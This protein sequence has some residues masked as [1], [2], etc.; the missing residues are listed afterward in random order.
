MVVKKLIQKTCYNQYVD[1]LYYQTENQRE[2]IKFNQ[3]TY[4]L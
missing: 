1:D 4:L 3:H 2:P